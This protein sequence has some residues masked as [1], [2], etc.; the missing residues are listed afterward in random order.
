MARKINTDHEFR[1][2]ATQLVAEYTEEHK[3]KTDAAEG[4]AVYVVWQVKALQNFKAL[5][6]TTMPDGMY[7]EVT[8]NGDTDEFYLDAYKK[9]ENRCI[10]VGRDKEE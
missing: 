1:V 9:F 6:A 3:D 2:K 5:L 8:Y 4:Y 7:Y 10:P